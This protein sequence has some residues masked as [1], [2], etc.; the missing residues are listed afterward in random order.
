MAAAVPVLGLFDIY[1]PQVCF[2]DQRGGFQSMTGRFASQLLRGKLEQF[3]VHQRQQLLGGVQIAVF[4]GIQD[5]G[6]IGRHK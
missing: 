1:Q 2:M 4:D 5:L 3:I 6:D